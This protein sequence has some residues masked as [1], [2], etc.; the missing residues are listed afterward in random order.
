MTT[1]LPLRKFEVRSRATDTVLGSIFAETI[2]HAAQIAAMRFYSRT[3]AQRV[4]GWTGAPGMFEP[5]T[6]AFDSSMVVY[7]NERFYVNR[8]PERP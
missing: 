6:R 4:T 2:W 7:T 3:G 5:T 8:A 1:P